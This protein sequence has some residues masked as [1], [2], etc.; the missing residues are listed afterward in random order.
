MNRT[1]TCI[2]AAIVCVSL[3]VDQ[4]AAAGLA[5]PFYAMDTSFQRPGLSPDEQLD[6][7]KELGFA[8]VAWSEQSP[9]QV[10]STVERLEKRGLKMFTIYCQAKVTSEGELTHS[11]HLTAIM[12]TLKGHGQDHLAAHRRQGARLRQA[13]GPGA[14]CREAAA[15]LRDGQGQRVA[16]RH[17]S[18]PR[19]VDRPIRRRHAAGQAGEPSEFWRL[20]QPVPLPG[21]GRRGENPQA[22]EE[23]RSVLFTVTISGADTGVSGGQWKRLIQTLDKGT[24]DVG[25]VLTKLRQI[26]FN[27]PIGFQGYGIAGDSRSILA[28]TMAAWKRLSA[29]Q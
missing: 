8:G 5:N 27:G 7:V 21:G 22:F 25:L 12:E 19:R 6:L 1:S 17:L 11:R 20:V 18:A 16:D 26:G 3:A 14:G 13:Y 4:A 29:G 2:L 9:N 23:A 15:A 10:Q 24:F 28:P